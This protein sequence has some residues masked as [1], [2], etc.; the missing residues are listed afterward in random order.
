ML[1]TGYW[2]TRLP[3]THIHIGVSRGTPR[4]MSS[5]PRMPQLAPGSWFH[6]VDVEEYRSRYVA[7]LAK[8]DPL[9]TVQQI[10]RLARGRIPVLCCY[11]KANDGHWCH[12]AYI[13]AWLCHH[14]GLVVEE[15][16]CIGQGYATSHPL[17]PAQYRQPLATPGIVRQ[18]RARPARIKSA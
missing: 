17:L 9:A 13:S 3:S 11:E 14:L 4:H 10:D 12:R 16:G 2:F 18:G 1:L 7:Q 15:Y 8:L 5:A 6:S